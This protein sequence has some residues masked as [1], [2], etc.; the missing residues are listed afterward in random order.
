MK[1][2]ASND[3]ENKNVI[4]VEENQ[5]SFLSYLLSEYDQDESKDKSGFK[6]KFNKFT[7]IYGCA[8]SGV[9][10]LSLNKFTLVSG[11][12]NKEKI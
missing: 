3:S 6:P 8:A 2:N 10:K 12:T 4:E 5:K 1:N 9:N 7:Q 11:N